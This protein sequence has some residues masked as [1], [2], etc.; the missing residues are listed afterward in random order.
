MFCDLSKAFDTVQHEILLDK[1]E[2][3]GLRGNTLKWFRSY[4]S[5]RKMFTQYKNNISDQV[6]INCGVPQG[7]ILGPLLFLIYVNDLSN[8]LNKSK[9]ILF[10][11]D[12]TIYIANSCTKILFQDTN[13]DIAS[14]KTWFDAN[15]LLLNS[16]KTKYVLFRS[17]NMRFDDELAISIGN[18]IIVRSSFTT[19]LGMNM[20][21][22]LNWDVHVSYVKKKISSA[23]YILRSVKH[24]LSCSNLRLLYNALVEPH[25][26]YG[27]LLWSNTSCKNINLIAKTQKKAIRIINKAKYNEP[28]SN[29]FKVSKVV[30]LDDMI[31][32]SQ[33]EFMYKYTH[34]QL[35]RG[36]MELFNVNSNVH[37]YETRQSNHP[38]VS[39]HK[40][41]L[42]NNSFLH[43]APRAFQSVSCDLKNKATLTS[44]K[45]TI[46]KLSFERY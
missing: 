35:P 42:F 37:Q 18:D 28:S 9:S 14:L 11:D 24:V 33:L 22:L 32:S 15:K 36:I 45:R 27:I 10:A 39:K 23:L 17:K 40:T 25:L 13:E 4:L 3:Y 5:N 43:K 20:D 41:S 30:K 8:S 1:L 34:D 7:S 12:T 38:H 31:S 2:N 26:M 19:F 6:S 44:F 21:E 46:K 16:Q 29:L